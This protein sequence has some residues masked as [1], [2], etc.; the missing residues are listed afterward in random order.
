[1]TLLAFLLVF[2]A[3]ILHATWNLYA[4]RVDSIPVVFIWLISTVGTVCLAPIGIAYWIITKPQY[5]WLEWFFIFGTA[6]IHIAYFISL[7]RGYK[8]GD[9]SLVY[10]IAR[11]T[12][13]LLTT[14]GAVLVLGER[15]GI[16]VI[17]GTLIIVSSVFVMASS[18]KA[19]GNDGPTNKFWPAIRYGLLT[20]FFIATY[21]LWDKYA[22]SVVLIAPFLYDWLNNLIRVVL[23][24]PSA[25]QHK[26]EV[27][28]VWK[29][30]KRNIFVVA[31]LSPLAYI[32]VLSAM[33]FTPASYV[34]PMRELSILIGAIFGATLLA[35]GNARVRLMAATGIVIG[36]ILLVIG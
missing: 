21:T 19:S 2:I 23:L 6:V 31:L 25:L 16:L 18:G 20:G 11:G 13:P 8:V 34:A 33:V 15:P 4:K 1:M 32:L 35:E 14:I 3:A 24:T 17:L 12:G 7:Q 22:V 27:K 26:A 29:N 28:R 9:L 5:G 10:P 30:S 36:V